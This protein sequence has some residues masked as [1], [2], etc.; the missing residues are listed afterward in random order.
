MIRV[1]GIVLGRLDIEGGDFTYGNRIALGQI[2]QDDSVSAYK[3][4]KSAFREL[5]GYSARLLPLRARVR[6]FTAIS[7]GV[8]AWIKKEQALLHYEP[9]ADELAA[10]L[11]DFSKRVG[12]I[13][14]P[15]ALARKYGCDPE[16][17]L[18]WSYAKVFGILWSDLE[19]AKYQRKLNKIINE[20]HTK[21]TGRR[22]R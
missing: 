17:I 15:N 6:R 20:R 7:R 5:Y 8:T 9:T 4:L 13:N 18:G 12:D 21:H 3:R 16:V 22:V 19:D 14:T 10:G 2:F 11:E 1:H